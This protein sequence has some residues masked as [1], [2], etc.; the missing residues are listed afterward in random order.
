VAEAWKLGRKGVDDGV[1]LLVARDN[2]KSLRR[3]RIEA[4]RGVQ[5]V[6]TD[7]QSKR[8]LQDTIAPHFRQ[9]RFLRRPGGRRRRD[10]HPAQPGKIPRPQPRKPQAQAGP[11]RRPRPRG[12]IFFIVIGIAWLRSLF[13]ARRPAQPRAARR[14]G[15]GSA[16][17]ASVIGNAS[18]I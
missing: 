6:L 2:P 5:G 14:N 10:R 1:L 3:L 7:A 16:S 9:K 17:P 8:I 15:W 13:A 12:C 18:V 4:G 11:G